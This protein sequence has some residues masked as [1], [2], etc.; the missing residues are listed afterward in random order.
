MRQPFAAGRSLV[1]SA[2]SSLV[3]VII[4]FEGFDARSGSDE[5]SQAQVSV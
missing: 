3:V 1:S 5:A 2:A 4:E